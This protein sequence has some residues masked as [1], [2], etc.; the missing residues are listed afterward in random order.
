MALALE[1][2]G[3]T[4]RFSGI[5]AINDVNFS[6]KKGEIH[7]L[8]GE[9]GAGKSTLMNIF[10]GLIQPDAG[11]LRI[12]GVPTRVISPQDAISQGI[13]MVHQRFMLIPTFSVT[14]NIML[15]HESVLPAT[16]GLGKLS[17][18]DRR[19]AAARIREIARQSGMEVDPHALV[20]DLPDGKR[21]QVEILKALYRDVD[22]LILDEPTA[23]LT[24]QEAD[25]VFVIMRTLVFQ[26]KSI[27]FVTNK[28]E[29]VF[30]AADRISVMR[31]AEVIGPVTPPEITREALAE[32]MAGNKAVEARHAERFHIK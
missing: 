17:L 13:A 12:N 18:L 10:Y 2:A 21:L 16:S 28:I 25:D 26:G 6:L 23:V 8:L 5:L 3:I 32:M 31:A 4:K 29:A 14:E 24:P 27:I 22:I 1:A 9:N 15:G 11:Q 20:R 19:S 30:A 7:T